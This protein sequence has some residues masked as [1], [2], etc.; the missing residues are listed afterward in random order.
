MKTRSKILIWSTSTRKISGE[1][2]LDESYFGARRVRGKCGRGASGKIPVF[3]LLKR[4][5]HVCVK[6]VEN[7][8]KK[9]LMPIIKGQ[10]QKGT[11]IYTDGWKAYDSLI[12]NGYKH[13]RVHHHDNEFARGTNHVNGIE[14]FLV[15]CKTTTLKIQWHF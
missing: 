1:V 13:Y 4:D 15:F 12:F 9:Q 14:S 10:I 6:I 7:Y 3:G 2:E 8:S 5:G 11:V